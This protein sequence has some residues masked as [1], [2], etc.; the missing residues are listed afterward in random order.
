MRHRGFVLHVRQLI[1]ILLRRQI[2]SS[3]RFC[4]QEPATELI[5]RLSIL[6]GVADS[7][8]GVWCFAVRNEGSVGLEPFL[9]A[10]AA[11]L[12]DWVDVFEMFCVFGGGFE[13]FTELR[14]S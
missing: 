1:P 6:I 4:P 11:A 14:V 8:T 10:W 2:R 13:V 3:G 7:A 12:I 9:A 5:N